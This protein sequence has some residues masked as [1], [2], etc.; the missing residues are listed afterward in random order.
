MIDVSLTF[1]SVM[2]TV[3]LYGILVRQTF[4][5]FLIIELKLFMTNSKIIN[6]NQSN[7]RPVEA[8]DSDEGQP[9]PRDPNE[10]DEMPI[11]NDPHGGEI[12][13]YDLLAN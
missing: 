6:V 11:R 1:I 13:V 10:E 7:D 3:I 5:H 9:N 2:L 12:T 8:D 4:N